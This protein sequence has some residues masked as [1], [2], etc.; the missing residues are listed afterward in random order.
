MNMIGID[1]NYFLLLIFVD[2]CFGSSMS[3]L[4]S[5]YNAEEEV[6]RYQNRAQVL[7]ALY[8]QLDRSSSVFPLLSSW[9]S[10]NP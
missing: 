7:V 9:F 1:S 10:S 8:I 3:E 4:S 5:S 2:V 6:A